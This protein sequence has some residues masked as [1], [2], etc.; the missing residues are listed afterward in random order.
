[1]RRINT[2]LKSLRLPS[3]WKGLG[4][5]CVFFTLHSS[6]FISP[7][8][9]EGLAT[10]RIGGNVYGGG[11]AA[12]VDGNATVTVKAG[13]LN[14]VFGGARMANIGGRTF[15]NIYG[16]AATSDIFI[17]EA[18]GGNDVAG[19]IGLSGEETTVPTEL[20]EILTGAETKETNPDKNAIDNTWKTFVRTYSK[21]IVCK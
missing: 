7:A 3:L 12:D 13:Y 5:C 17:V 1:M 4:V 10:I 9:A 8:S 20:T 2:I 19:T 11:N 14:K 15:V 6:L 18:Y 21:I 16:E